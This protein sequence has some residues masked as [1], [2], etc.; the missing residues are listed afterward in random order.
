[1]RRSTHTACKCGGKIVISR[2]IFHLLCKATLEMQSNCVT[3]AKNVHTEDAARE[4]SKSDC[5]ARLEYVRNSTY[6]VTQSV[7]CST[8]LNT[9]GKIEYVLDEK[10]KH[11]VHR[12]RQLENG[13]VCTYKQTSFI[14]EY[15]TIGLL[16]LLLPLSE[17]RSVLALFSVSVCLSLLVARFL[18]LHFLSLVRVLA[19]V[20]GTVFPLNSIHIAASQTAV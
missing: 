3:H 17:S 12:A 18:L 7:C 5:H 10:Q 15:T 16:M 19:R 8:K 6:N 9:W 4:R 20:N 13:Y 2:L 1:M 14:L 11:S